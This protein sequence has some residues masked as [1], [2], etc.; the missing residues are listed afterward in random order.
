MTRLT[1]LQEADSHLLW[2][3]TVLLTSHVFYKKSSKSIEKKKQKTTVM[4]KVKIAQLG[5]SI[6]ALF[7]WQYKSKKVLH[8]IK[9]ELKIV[10]WMNY[11]QDEEVFYVAYILH[12]Q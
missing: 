8:I 2:S 6:H 10:T 11:T 9:S 7:L 1:D 4:G 3:R 5:K 12:P